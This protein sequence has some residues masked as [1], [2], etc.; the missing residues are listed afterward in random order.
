MAT[1]PVAERPT[2][3][4]RHTRAAAYMAAVAALCLAAA[5]IIPNYLV[6]PMGRETHLMAL[7]G[8]NN[9]AAPWTLAFGMGGMVIAYALIIPVLVGL[10]PPRAAEVGTLLLAALTAAFAAYLIRHASSLLIFGG[11]SDGLADSVSVLAFILTPLP[12]LAAA[13]RLL[14]TAELNAKQVYLGALL[15]HIGMLAA[16]LAANPFRG[17][18]G[19]APGM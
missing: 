18:G 14:A 5:T 9:P 8:P 13:V 16:M 15:L 12:I 7:F 1:A 11:G 17:F 2:A 19:V 10:L 3:A 6:E 4:G